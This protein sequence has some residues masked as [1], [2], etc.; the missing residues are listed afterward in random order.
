MLSI[1]IHE[2]KAKLSECLAAIEVAET[3]QICC[4]FFMTRST[5][6]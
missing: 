3:V 6:C 2:A 4:P 5:A 1:N